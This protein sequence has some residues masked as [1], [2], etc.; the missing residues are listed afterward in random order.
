MAL[1]IQ[2]KQKDR[3]PSFA[4]SFKVGAG[5][6]LGQLP[7]EIVGRGFGGLAQYLVGSGLE[8]RRTDEAMT[9]DLAKKTLADYTS[10]EIG[11]KKATGTIEAGKSLQTK[12]PLQPEAPVGKVADENILDS[13]S[14]ELRVT[15]PD[16][17]WPERAKAQ[18]APKNDSVTTDG[19]TPAGLTPGGLAAIVGAKN[20]SSGSMTTKTSTSSM[21][22]AGQTAKGVIEATLPVATEAMRRLNT[23][24]ANASDLAGGYGEAEMDVYD[25]AGGSQMRYL[26]DFYAEAK[27]ENPQLDENNIRDKYKLMAITTALSNRDRERRS[28]MARPDAISQLQHS[29]LNQAKVAGE[30]GQAS[31]D[32]SAAPS[33]ISQEAMQQSGKMDEMKFKF[34]NRPKDG[35][36]RDNSPTL[37]E[38]QEAIDT[39]TAIYEAQR[40]RWATATEEDKAAISANLAAQTVELKDLH[41]KYAKRKKTHP[42]EIAGRGTA[43]KTL[44]GVE[45]AEADRKFKEDEATKARTAAAKLEAQRMFAIEQENKEKRRAAIVTKLGPLL[46]PEALKQYLEEQ[47]L[48]E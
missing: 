28:S 17:N 32:V 34:D 29:G 36:E 15:R 47:G 16:L 25:K 40:A 9:Q 31:R 4:D 43:Y 27:A 8:T 2:R 44:T 35:P 38:I 13:F 46:P 30:L 18:N 5:Q 33:R 1:V 7:A 19:E 41:S 24:T 10:G 11:E 3:K 48:G 45:K 21:D 26:E 14:D 20:G 22:R 39:Q 23:N 12:T 6:S 37:D 42:N